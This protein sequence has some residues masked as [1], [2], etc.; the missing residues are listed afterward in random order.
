M[1][2]FH[3]DG[4]ALLRSTAVAVAMIPL[5][6]MAFAKATDPKA[7]TCKAHVKKH[8][9]SDRIEADAQSQQA[10][11]Q[12]QDAVM[13]FQPGLRAR[14]VSGDEAGKPSTDRNRRGALEPGVI[15]TCK[16]SPRYY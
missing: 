4:R 9:S 7:T 11:P 14:D 8:K 5:F 12:F 2:R 16:D 15:A 10:L 13:Y 3:L 1:K 6:S